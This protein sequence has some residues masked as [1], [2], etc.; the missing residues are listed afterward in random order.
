VIRALLVAALVVAVFAG[1][2]RWGG[3]LRSG[4]ESL[5]PVDAQATSVRRTVVAEAQRII[6]NPPT[7]TATPE[8]T[9]IPRPSCPNAIWWHE[10][11]A[12]LGEVRTIQGAVIATRPAPNGTTL[13]ELGQPYPD[14]NGVAV[15]I[16]AQLA[17]GL[18]AKNVCAAGRIENAEGRATIQVRDRSNLVVLGQ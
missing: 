7:A 2:A 6:A 5:S 13:I 3:A 10:A 1:F 15:L 11:R 9:P 14:P 4:P 17:A 16:P 12:H 18:N 8:A